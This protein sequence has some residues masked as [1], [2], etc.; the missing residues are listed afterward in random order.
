MGLQNFDESSPVAEANSFIAA[1]GTT[2]KPI[3]TTTG[4]RVRVD[5]IIAANTDTIAH[6]ITLSYFDGTARVILGS[7]SIPAGQGTAGTPGLDILA[8]CL[9]ASITGIVIVPNGYIQAG[10]AVAVTG[11]NVVQLLTLGG[12]V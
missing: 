10:L 6:V 8:P 12:T 5:V 3:T 9:P 2:G 11:A 7:V 1:D 4:L